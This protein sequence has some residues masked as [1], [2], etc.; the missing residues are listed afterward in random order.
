MINLDFN[1]VHFLEEKKKFD[2]KIKPLVI[3]FSTIVLLATGIIFYLSVFNKYTIFIDII[4]FLVFIPFVF[5]LVYFGFLS[6]KFEYNFWN[7]FAKINN[8]VFLGPEFFDRK[9]SIMLRQGDGQLIENM[10]VFKNEEKEILRIFTF[11]FSENISEKKTISHTYIVFNFIF[12]G[13]F[14]NIYLNYK[15]DRFGISLKKNLPLPGE[16]EKKFTASV[17]SG[18][19]IEG[20]EI[21][22]PE[23]LAKILELEICVDIELVGQNAFFFLEKKPSFYFSFEQYLKVIE[24]NYKIAKDLMLILKPKLDRFS[25]EKIGDK[26]FNF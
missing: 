11:S 15:K 19:E 18:Y 23:I 14:P 4:G 26:N 22:S 20:L 10:I 12:L 5:S 21:F 7:I 3:I 17:A 13:E 16:F 24:R 8:G 25:F 6:K 9:Q 1:K 2:K